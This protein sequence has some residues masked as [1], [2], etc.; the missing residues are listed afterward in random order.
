MRET[1]SLRYSREQETDPYKRRFTWPKWN[2]TVTVLDVHQLFARLPEFTGW[3]ADRHLQ[4]SRDYLNVAHSYRQ[5]QSDLIARGSRLYGDDGALIAGG[6][7]EHWPDALKD[8][9]RVHAHGATDF[10]DKSL[11]HWQAAGR[12][13]ATWRQE[14]ERWQ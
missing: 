11:A 6:F 10:S 2:R 3:T 1:K 8:A 13:V 12:R 9:I 5:C 7:R 4:A 14:R